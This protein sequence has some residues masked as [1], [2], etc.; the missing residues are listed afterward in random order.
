M[1]PLIATGW[2]IYGCVMAVMSIFGL[3]TTALWP[4]KIT[5]ALDPSA[6]VLTPV[7]VVI[8]PLQM[9]AVTVACYNWGARG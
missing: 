3:L 8:V 6:H 4:E 1:R 2:F 7:L 5:L 9:A